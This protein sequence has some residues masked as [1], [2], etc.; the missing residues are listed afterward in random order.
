MEFY[1]IAVIILIALAVGDLIVGVSNDAVNFLNSAIGS[2]VASRRTIFVVASAGI[3]LGATF[4]SGMMEIARRGIFN[5]QF[6]TFDEIMILFLAVMITDIILLDFFNTFGLPTSTTVSIVFELLGAALVVSLFKIAKAGEGLAMLP[7]YINSSKALAIIMGIFVSVAV[8]FIVGSAVQYVSRLLFTFDY[9]R[10]LK[11]VGAVWSGLALSFMTYFLL[12]KGVKGASFVNA[13]FIAWVE[14]NTWLLIGLLV[15]IWSLVCQVM[16]SFGLNVFRL[17]VLV[18]TFSLAMAFAGN[19][20]VNFIGVPIA[21]LESYRAWS[22]SGVDPG[23]FFM[24]ALAIPVQTESWM[25]L[26]AGAIMAATLW[27]SKKAQSVTKTEVN[28]GRQDDGVERFAPNEAARMT[29]RV[30][31]AVA[32]FLRPLVPPSLREKS[33]AAFRP[34][35]RPGKGESNRPAF[36]LI[37]ASVNLAVASMLIAFATSLK[38][39]LSTTYVTFMV[40][41]GSSLSDRA[42]GRESAVYRVAGVLSVI[43]GW[44]MTALIAFV[45]S[46]VFAWLLWTLGGF[47]LLTLSLVVAGS[48]ARGYHIFRKRA[49][50]ES[51]AEEAEASA[52]E[53]EGYHA[54]SEVFGRATRLLKEV[55]DLYADCLSALF[56]EKNKVLRRTRKRVETLKEEN[57][58]LGHSLPVMIR[59]HSTNPQ[60]GNAF[61]RLFDEMNEIL[62]SLNAIVD[63]CHTYVNNQHSPL[64]KSQEERLLALQHNLK[65][66]L[67]HVIEQMK[68][69]VDGK[70]HDLLE[71]RDRL[72]AEIGSCYAFQVEGLND[73]RFGRKNSQLMFRILLETKDIVGVACRLPDLHS[74]TFPSLSDP[75]QPVSVQ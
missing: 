17:V 13:D 20:L 33:D 66:Y 38:L 72:L 51:L 29:V 57:D 52:E 31:L 6:F 36:D 74:W 56:A 61:V 49:R 25:L 35:P 68:P 11:M 44:F 34:A 46:G 2:K 24:T 27:L 43:G 8:A 5:P 75:E 7:M 4:S 62:L 18:G 40:A 1:L 26:L 21:G 32:N 50:A 9:E 37:R 14:A 55:T 45:V 65:R 41:M 3:V 28:L 23:S 53:S 64:D 19:D 54:F 47:G 67:R 16:I 10:R 48:V 22:G 15:V 63:A 42:W 73:Q 12:V 60:L 58:L 59:K 30:T 70:G 69:D 39:P 71:W